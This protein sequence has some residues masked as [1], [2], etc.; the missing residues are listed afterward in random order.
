V[1]GQPILQ[2][3]GVLAYVGAIALFFVGLALLPGR[4]SQRLEAF[5]EARSPTVVAVVDA[6]EDATGGIS[7]AAA[8]EAEPAS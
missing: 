7:R 3:A 4:M 8:T 5:N 2:A 6:S 1:R